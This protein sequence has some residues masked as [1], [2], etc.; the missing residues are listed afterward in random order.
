MPTLAETVAAAR[1]RLVAGGIPS[2]EAPGDAE[3]LARHAL[4]WDLT[5][6]VLYRGEAPPAAFSSRYD[7]LIARRLGREPVSQ[8][9]GVREFWGMDFEVSRDVLTPRP[10][11]E[12]I[13]EE[14]LA[15]FPDPPRGMAIVDVGTGSGCLAVALAK[16]FP[17]AE[18]IATDISEA[19]L[20]VAQRNARRHGVNNRI[21]FVHSDILPPMQPVDL[22][23]SNPPY[24]PGKE[25]ASLPPEVR[26]FE[27]EV[28][29]FA[30]EDGLQ[31]Y[32][33][34]F[35]QAALN[36]LRPDGRLIVELGYDQRDRVA[37]LAAR[38]GWRVV[39]TRHDLQG[40]PRVLILQ[41]E[42]WS[43]TS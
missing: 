26:N 14:A 33:R 25:A 10:E 22:I 28:A 1:E 4:G 13:V 18:M 30:A 16:E 15:A 32:R 41:P 35:E 42:A 40:I 39:K 7:V 34:L 9:V 23:V 38:L 5:R 31:F 36:S 21:A 8:I 37:A 19:A 20:A 17:T 12:L 2:D 3:V 27:P 24:I 6:Y 43:P 11:T 29:L